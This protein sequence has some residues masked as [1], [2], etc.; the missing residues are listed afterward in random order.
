[1]RRVF[2]GAISTVTGRRIGAPAR[3][4]S[5]LLRA[6]TTGVSHW[7]VLF[8]TGSIALTR[9][10]IHRN[11]VVLETKLANG[12]PLIQGDRILLQQVI[13]NLIRNAIEAMNGVDEGRADCGS[14]P[15]W[16]DRIAACALP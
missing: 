7:A 15:R 4:L 14:A 2:L 9:G 6:R 8:A 5:L 3:V 11:S 12:L 10:E 13:L 1:M 16:T